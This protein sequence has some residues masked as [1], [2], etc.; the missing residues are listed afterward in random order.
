[1]K[2][3]KILGALSMILSIVLIY[4]T[5]VLEFPVGSFTGVMAVL[6]KVFSVVLLQW[7]AKLTTL[8]PFAEEGPLQVI[9]LLIHLLYSY[10]I[11]ALLGLGISKILRVVP[12]TSSHRPSDHFRKVRKARK[13]RGR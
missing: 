4:I 6:G 10:G 7:P 2:L 5:R 13:H 9:F 12:R 8:L 11:G 3:W 1:M